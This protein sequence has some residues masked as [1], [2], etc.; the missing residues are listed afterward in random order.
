[1]ALAAELSESK[2]YFIKILL[3]WEHSEVDRVSTLE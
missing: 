2:G 1:M 3:A